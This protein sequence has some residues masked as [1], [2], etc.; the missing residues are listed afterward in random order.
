MSASQRGDHEAKVKISVRLLPTTVQMLREATLKAGFSD[1]ISLYAQKLLESYVPTVAK[2]DRVN[3]VPSEEVRHERKTQTLTV[4]AT[5]LYQY[6]LESLRLHMRRR[7]D[8][9]EAVLILALGHKS[10]VVRR[11]RLLSAEPSTDGKSMTIGENTKP[12]KH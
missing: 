4:S 8:L 9:I 11:R 10:E 6:S 2:W 3:G 5:L 7:T 1:Q 12:D